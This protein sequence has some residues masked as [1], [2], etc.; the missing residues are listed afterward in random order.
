VLKD[1][2]VAIGDQL[3]IRNID[4]VGISSSYAIRRATEDNRQR[5]GLILRRQDDGVE[6]NAVAHGNHDF[7]ACEWNARILRGLVADLLSGI[8]PAAF[9]YNR[10]HCAAGIADKIDLHVDDFQEELAFGCRE[11]LD[12]IHVCGLY[13]IL[14]SFTKD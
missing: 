11:D 4:P 7:A 9:M 3:F 5:L 10:S 2:D 12:L 6:T 13:V 8:I 1:E 14:I